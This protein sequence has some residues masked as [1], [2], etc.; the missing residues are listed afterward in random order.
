LAALDNV[1]L[2]SKQ[3]HKCI[4]A[5][6]NLGKANTVH[7]RWVKAHIGITGNELADKLAKRG[8]LNEANYNQG[9]P[10]PLVKLKNNIKTYYYNKWHSLWKVH[11]EARQ[12]KIWFQTPDPNL[13]RKLLEIPRPKLGL[14]IQFLTGHNNLMRHKAICDPDVD[15]T[16]RL[17]LEEEESSFHVIAECPVLQ[18]ARWN[19]FHLTTLQNPPVWSIQQ[20]TRFLK[21]TTIGDLLDQRE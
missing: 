15:S 16:C 18:T 1:T 4:T 8:A 14:L 5:L 12:T 7:L 9:I 3:V 13:S 19:N 11:K 17:C 10:I 6:N 21:E 20:V 2:N